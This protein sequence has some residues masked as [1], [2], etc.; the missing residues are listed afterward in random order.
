MRQAVYL[1]RIG[2]E[3]IHILELI[4]QIQYITKQYLLPSRTREK[5]MPTY[6]SP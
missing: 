2:Q 4:Y 5:Q 6:F 3:G 1:L